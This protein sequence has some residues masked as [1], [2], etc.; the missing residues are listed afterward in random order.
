[1]R[2][3][4]VVAIVALVGVLGFSAQA[5]AQGNDL[6]DVAGWWATLNCKYMVG[7]AMHSGAEVA[8]D[9]AG[10]AGGGYTAGTDRDT[11]DEIQWCHMTFEGLKLA[12]R[13]ALNTAVTSGGTD[14]ADRITRKPSVELISAKGWWNA[15]TPDAQD[16]AVGGLLTQVAVDGLGAGEEV[17]FDDLT[18]AQN[19]R[20]VDSYMGLLKGATTTMPEPTPALPLVGLGV[21]GLLLAG[22]GAYLR[23][24]RA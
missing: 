18:V 10:L 2:N 11:P 20:V 13:A 22:R 14:G 1:M 3:V 15:L 5:Q 19:K 23:R 7:A 21:L 17:D 9:G 24:R 8:V 12:D 4:S 16:T 6:T